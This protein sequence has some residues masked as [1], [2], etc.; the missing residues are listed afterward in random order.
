MHALDIG[1]GEPRGDRGGNQHPRRQAIEALPCTG[2]VLEL[3]A[4]S[5]PSEPPSGCLPASI[6]RPQ[7]RVPD[8]VLAS[9]DPPSGP[10]SAVA[11]NR[12]L[13]E[14]ARRGS[15]GPD[16]LGMILLVA[17]VE[18]NK[19]FPPLPPHPRGCCL[20]PLDPARS[21]CRLGRGGRIGLRANGGRS[22]CDSITSVELCSA[23]LLVWKDGRGARKMC[24]LYADAG[25]S[26]SVR[27]RVDCSAF[28]ASMDQSFVGSLGSALDWLLEEAP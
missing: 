7:N 13:W 3:A 25:V 8:A 2:N 28:G 16:I 20:H 23:S 24:C 17:A 27:S 26:L 12:L 22:F 5:I 19:L 18:S 15:F 10:R 4:L 1:V 6:L 11:G 9:S 21:A 14:E